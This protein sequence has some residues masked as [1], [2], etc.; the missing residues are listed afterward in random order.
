MG[1]LEPEP[2]PKFV[3]ATPCGDLVRASFALD[4]ALLYGYTTQAC[5]ECAVVQSRG[6]ILPQQRAE[7]AAKAI[8]YGATHLLFVD[9]DMRFPKDALI[10]LYNRRRPIV[11]ANYVRRRHPALPTAEKGPKDF[12]YTE[13]ESNGLV[14]VLR[15]GLGLCLIETHVFQAMSAPWFSI[16]FSGHGYVGEDVFFC[17]KAREAGF[18]L[19]VDQTL[20]QSVRHAGELD[21]T[22]EHS[23]M[24]RT[25]IEAVQQPKL[26]LVSR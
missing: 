10:Q 23:L 20:S 2:T 3:I 11:G 24:L 6:T 16:G 17:A 19:Y 15:M 25:K 7:L 14:E 5:V 9:S 18:S 22:H 12:L 13:P 21:Y 26:E 1:A 4:L 8:E